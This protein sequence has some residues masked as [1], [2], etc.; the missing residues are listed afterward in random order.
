MKKNQI[1]LCVSFIGAFLFLSCDNST[2]EDEFIDVNGDVKEK[3]IKRIEGFNTYGESEIITIN[4]DGQNRVSSFSDGET[5]KFLNYGNSGEL[6]LVS[7]SSEDTSLTISDLYKAPY[8]VFDKGDVLEFD[9]NGNPT[10]ILAYEKGYN[11]TS[12]IGDVFYES[13][14][15]PFFYTFKAAKLIEVLDKVNLNFGYTNPDIMKARQLLPFNNI[16]GMIFKTSSG[17]TKYEVQFDYDY[18]AD[19]YPISALV[20]SFD[21][22]GSNTYLIKYYYR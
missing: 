10:K 15:N 22:N 16:S 7:G 3:Y 18:D 13:N 17:I 14:P 21:E 2:I 6:N 1:L 11:S 19:G 4:Y 5:I 9:N 20:S 8:D 12:L